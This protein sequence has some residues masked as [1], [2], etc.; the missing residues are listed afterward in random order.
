MR[1]FSP[2]PIL[3]GFMFLVCFGSEEDVQAGPAFGFGLKAG[4]NGSN[5]TNEKLTPFSFEDAERSAEGT[6]KLNVGKF[7]F[8]G[9][10]YASLRFAR[11]FGVQ[12][13]AL[14]TQKGGEGY[15]S[16]TVESAEDGRI[17]LNN[18]D[19]TMKL[20]Y[21]EVPILANFS[22]FRVESATINFLFGPYVAQNIYAKITTEGQVDQ[23]A[24]TTSFDI[25]ESVKKTDFGWVFAYAVN[26]KRGHNAIMME[27]RY[28]F[29][30]D[31]VVESD[32]YDYDLK[33]RTFSVLMSFGFF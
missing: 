4:F 23:E 19:L 2:V 18:N 17:K 27:F 16:A 24:Y 13:E 28:T 22:L 8:T 31:T 20:D 26:L 30:T 10:G 11:W 21:I 3:V 32:T 15:F 5:I 33:M 25:A 29:G 9:G 14:Y 1:N 7:G 6:M 12:V